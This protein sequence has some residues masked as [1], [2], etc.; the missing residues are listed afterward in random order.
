MLVIQQNEATAADR[1]IPFRLI[2]AN[3]AAVTA[4]TP[5]VRVSKQYST[6]TAAAAGAVTEIDATNMPGAYFYEATAGEVDTLGSLLLNITAAGAIALNVDVAIVA[7]DPTTAPSDAASVADA[8]WDEARAGHVAAGSFGEGVA[9]VQGNVTGSVASVSGA[10]GG[11]VAGSVASVTGN[12]GGNV[13]GSVGSVTGL[14]AAA[15][16]AIVDDLEDAGRLDLLI[17][18][19]KAKT[20]SL[21][22][23]GSFVQADLQATDGSAISQGGSAPASPIGLT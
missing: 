11:N 17:D 19:I 15:L 4:A 6:T 5:T 7:Y 10:V 2:D 1:R 20:D 23:T 21:T 18:A 13:V 12:V 9:S 3:G 16:Q 14:D 22:F 8:V